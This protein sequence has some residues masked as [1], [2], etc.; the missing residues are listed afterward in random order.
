MTGYPHGGNYPEAKQ[1]IGRDFSPGTEEKVKG[2]L[3]DLD[4]DAFGRQDPERI[5]ASMVLASD[6]KWE[7]FMRVFRLLTVD[8]RDLLVAGG[9]A[10]GDWP[11]L[12][13]V[14]LP[15]S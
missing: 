12:L 8:W 10:D 15:D 5:Q 6:R 7:R 14:E 11:A 9:L 4:A 3:A 1:R 13:N 2:C